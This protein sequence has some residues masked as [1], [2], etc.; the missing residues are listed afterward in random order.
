MLPNVQ[1]M[2][3]WNENLD[4]FTQGYSNFDSIAS[5]F[6]YLSNFYSDPFLD[7]LPHYCFAVS[8][9]YGPNDESCTLCRQTT[10]SEKTIVNILAQA[11]V[12]WREYAEDSLTV[13]GSTSVVCSATDQNYLSGNS[14][15]GGYFERHDFLLNFA[16]TGNASYDGQSSGWVNMRRFNLPG[17]PNDTDSEHGLFVDLANGK[18]PNWSAVVPNSYND[19]HDNQT[20]VNGFFGTFLDALYASPQWKAGTMYVLVTADNSI[21]NTVGAVLMNGNY[22]SKTITTAWGHDSW[23]AT[24]EDVF[25][26]S[27][28]QLGQADVSLTNGTLTSLI[29]TTL[30]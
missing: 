1:L 26:G 3:Y 21:T 30:P 4:Y 11:G 16:S 2:M 24:A 13:P 28:G 9:I 5:K 27:H 18:L 29:M 12:S 14:N 23:L 17:D 20:Y 19:G 8:G 10:G 7:S 15:G 25:L 6:Y 22:S